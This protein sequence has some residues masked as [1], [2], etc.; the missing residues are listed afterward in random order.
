MGGKEE[1]DSIFVEINGREKK[2][3]RREWLPTWHL[4]RGKREEEK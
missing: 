2:G 1:K 3:L 4:S